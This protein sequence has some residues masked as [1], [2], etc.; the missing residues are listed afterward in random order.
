MAP[1]LTQTDA[2]TFLT[3][4][5]YDLKRRVVSKVGS[6]CTASAA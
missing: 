5:A 6:G 4:L 2:R 3:T 1:L